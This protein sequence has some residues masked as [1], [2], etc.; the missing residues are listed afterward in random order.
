MSEPNVSVV[1]FDLD[2]TL[3]VQPTS[4]S[5]ALDA[6][7]QRIGIEPF[8]SLED[9]KQKTD[10]YG[11]SASMP[12]RYYR[13]CEEL[14]EEV[15]LDREVGIAVASAIHAERH[16]AAVEFMPGAQRV[17]DQLKGQYRLGLVTNGGPDTQDQ[18][19]EALDI[20]DYFE[21]VVLAGVETA[22]KPDPE[23]FRYALDEMGVA[24]EQGIYV[25]NSVE[26]DVAGAHAAGLDAVWV[27]NGRSGRADAHEAEYVVDSLTDL[28]PP[29]WEDS[30]PSEESPDR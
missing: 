3:C 10:A 7:F 25:G 2:S 22:P 26:H 8:F 19:I 18:K 1:F 16:E 9:L 12:Y 5:D 15:N 21:V 11:H 20:R 13:G 30:S 27:R 23:P 17:L 6:A 29:P 4:R 14:A 28:V 24:P